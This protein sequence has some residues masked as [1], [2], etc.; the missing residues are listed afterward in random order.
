MTPKTLVRAT[1]LIAIV[2]IILLMY[3]LFAFILIQV[4]GLRVFQR[5]LTELFALSVMGVVALMAAAL[6]LNMML[7]LTRIAERGSDTVQIKYFKKIMYLIVAGFP[8]LAALLFGGHHL[9]VQKKQQILVQ[10][11][12]SLVS[13][14]SKQAQNLAHY[15]FDAAYV[16][17]TAEILSIWNKKDSAFRYVNVIVRDEIDGEKVWLAFGSGDAIALQTQEN[18]KKTNYLYAADLPTR[19]YLQEAFA[20]NGDNIR[21]TEQD[22]SYDLYYPYVENGKVLA[23]FHFSD[24]QRYGKLG[25]Y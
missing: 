14:H 17:K 10:S 3:W 1:N 7:N 2:A 20:G 15:R 9:T 23:V 8:L 5:S 22:G 16:N 18:I 21:F 6:M 11:A 19:E 24:Y 12:I 4:F 25:S 13:E